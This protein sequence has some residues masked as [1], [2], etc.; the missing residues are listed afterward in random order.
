M[1][2]VDMCISYVVVC[3]SCLSFLGA[4]YVKVA[5]DLVT[6]STAKSVIVDGG[7]FGV[8]AQVVFDILD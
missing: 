7:I 6:V 4:N 8:D 1:C 5:D 2:L 3:F